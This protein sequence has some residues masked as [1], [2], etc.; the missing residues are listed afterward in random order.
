M[1]YFIR[2]NLPSPVPRSSRVFARDVVGQVPDLSPLIL[3]KLFHHVADRYET[4][5]PTVLQH[6]KVADP[7]LGHHGHALLDRI[8][9]SD[10][11]DLGRHDRPDL[12][13]L[14]SPPLQDDLAQI[15]ALGYDAT[16]FTVI[17]DEQG[18]DVVI[19]HALHGIVNAGPAFNGIHVTAFGSNQ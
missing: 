12:R 16:D 8:V 6:G 4:G 18:A 10:A 13:G 3:G 1:R 14:R 15:V 11:H 2:P 17:D 5:Q 7:L 9:G 19:H